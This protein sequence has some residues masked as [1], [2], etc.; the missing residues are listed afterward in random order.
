MLV[1]PF[2]DPALPRS[3]SVLFGGS[4]GVSGSNVRT[5]LNLLFFCAHS[6]ENHLSTRSGGCGSLE[7]VGAIRCTCWNHQNHRIARAGSGLP[8]PHAFG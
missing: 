4:S 6:T 8:L 2:D 1:Q 3:M 5:R 7:T